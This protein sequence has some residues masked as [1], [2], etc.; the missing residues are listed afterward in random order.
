[1]TPE[2]L[3][4]MAL[5][6]QLARNLTNPATTDIVSGQALNDIL[7]DLRR[8][9]ADTAAADMPAAM[10]KLLQP[11]E[12]PQVQVAAVRALGTDAAARM[13]D[14]WARYTAPVRRE[15][16]PPRSRRFRLRS[17]CSSATACACSWS[18]VTRCLCS[19]PR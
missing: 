13:L 16:A 1:M 14:G 18:S 19:P 3:R 4:Q 6:Q 9:G 17:K 10:E 11:E 5:Q 8:R 2:E 15:E 7:A 12:P